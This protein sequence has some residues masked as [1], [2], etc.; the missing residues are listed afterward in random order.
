MVCLCYNHADTV[1][2][3]IE[4]VLSQKTDFPFEL[5]VHD[6]C[7]TDGTADTVRRYAEKYPDVIV[8]VLQSENRMKSCNIA[9]TYI[10][11]LLRGRFVAICEGDDYWLSP[12]KLQKQTEVMLGDPG[13]TMC[14]HAVMQLDSLGRQ[15]PFRPVKGSSFVPSPIIV[16]RGGMFCPSVSLMVRRDIA[17]MWPDFRRLADVYDYPLQV[18]S[19]AEGKVYYIDEIMAVYRFAHRG[20]WTASMSVSND[21]THIENE[22][23]WLSLFNERYNGRFRYE[24]DYHLAHLWLTEY[25]KT[26][27]PE[28]KQ[29]AVESADLLGMKDRITFRLLILMF[30]LLGKRGEAVYG[31][32]KKII[33]K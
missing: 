20:S 25:R 19:A 17:D 33:L 10:A 14:F 13:I 18:L 9:E 3:A 7:S 31:F 8:P 28:L 16:K 26:F 24:T 11:P 2:G 32:I 12:D 22:I 30:S 5:I 1:A 29:K 23:K 21:F 6:D 15:T 27:S 4:S